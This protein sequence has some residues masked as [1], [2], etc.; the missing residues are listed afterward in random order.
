VRPIR[1]SGK[2]IIV[3]DGRLLTIK[4]QDDEGFFYILPG[5]GQHPGETLTSAVVRECREEVSVD[6]TVGDM[7]CMREC[8]GKNQPPVYLGDVN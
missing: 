4:N 7:V 1:N 6:V 8:I 3:E 5:G 2:A